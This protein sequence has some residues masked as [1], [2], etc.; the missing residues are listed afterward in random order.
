MRASNGRVRRSP[1]K[2]YRQSNKCGSQSASPKPSQVLMR[3]R[4]EEFLPGDLVFA[5]FTGYSWP[6]IVSQV[7]AKTLE[8]VTLILE[9]DEIIDKNS[10]V[11]FQGKE[12]LKQIMS[13][14]TPGEKQDFAEASKSLMELSLKSRQERLDIMKTGRSDSDEG[15]SS[16]ENDVLLGVQD[17]P[18]KEIFPTPTL[19]PPSPCPPRQ[20]P[21]LSPKKEV[22]SDSNAEI[23]KLSCDINDISLPIVGSRLDKIIDQPRPKLTLEVGGPNF[24][25][26]DCPVSSGGESE[27]EVRIPKTVDKI[28]TIENGISPSKKKKLQVKQQRDEDFIAT[29]V[30][31]TNRLLETGGK[32]VELIPG[33]HLSYDSLKIARERA[34]MIAGCASPIIGRTRRKSVSKSAEALQETPEDIAAKAHAEHL[35]A[36]RAAQ[37]KALKCIGKPLE[38]VQTT[39]KNPSKRPGRKPSL[40]HGDGMLS[41]IAA[42]IAFHDSADLLAP[43][44]EAP[45]IGSPTRTTNLQPTAAVPKAPQDMVPFHRSPHSSPIKSPPS[46]RKRR[47]SKRQSAAQKNSEIIVN[48]DSLIQLQKSIS[49]QK[50]V[51][52]VEVKLNEEQRKAKITAIRCESLKKA[53]EVKEQKRAEK[54][55]LGMTPTKACSASENPTDKASNALAKKGAKR[56]LIKSPTIEERSPGELDEIKERNRLA[57]VESMQKVREANFKNMAQKKAFLAD[58]ERYSQEHNN[59]SNK[60]TI[61]DEKASKA[62]IEKNCQQD[63]SGNNKAPIVDKKRSKTGT[64]RKSKRIEDT[65]ITSTAFVETK[66][67]ESEETPS[68]ES[69]K[70]DSTDNQDG[71]STS[72][73][74]I[75]SYLCPY[76]LNLFT[77]VIKEKIESQIKLDLEKL[78]QEERDLIEKLVKGTTA[79]TKKQA[80]AI[81]SKLVKN[82]PC[83]NLLPSSLPEVGPGTPP[84]SPKTE[85]QRV[86]NKVIPQ[87]RKRNSNSASQQDVVHNP[88]P[89]ETT[90]LDDKSRKKYLESGDISKKL[91]FMPRTW[92][93]YLKN[94]GRFATDSKS[95]GSP[96][97]KLKTPNKKISP[98][99]GKTPNKRRKV[100]SPQF[101][102]EEVAIPSEHKAKAL[103]LFVKDIQISLP[104]PFKLT[105][106]EVK[107]SDLS[108]ESQSKYI[109]LCETLHDLSPED[110]K[111]QCTALDLF[112]QSSQNISR[113]D[114]L[115]LSPSKHKK[116]LNQA[117]RVTK[118][119]AAQ[120]SET[121]E[122][123]EKLVAKLVS[124]ESRKRKRET[125]PV[126]TDSEPST[127]KE[128]VDDTLLDFFCLDCFTL[129]KYNTGEFEHMTYF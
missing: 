8:V 93:Q 116:F 72:N 73:G 6:A 37:K 118:K 86:T 57:K 58:I 88:F 50:I 25:P 30:E 67:P 99:D 32:S 20:S 7:G 40:L 82:S 51:S 49:P 108:P 56:Q 92:S 19:P 113:L 15:E 23:K 45:Q 22:I 79:N 128:K 126:D 31:K 84:A 62:D 121:D 77:N 129:G 123:S 47:Q 97:D 101:L 70:T 104:E 27:V 120:L 36:T 106:T 64:R 81:I 2:A 54:R 34:M 14:L 61:V 91:P 4:G 114:W 124:S 109:E 107:W 122:F 21:K 89:V 65:E 95:S 52:P 85:V 3:R 17:E 29:A 117:K 5:E 44:V 76:Y 98:K 74:D 41:K 59:A 96:A 11:I 60:T 71:P 26:P 43:T 127:K 105:P 10:A 110:R 53:R 103:L 83:Q 87:S 33:H 13:V 102:K 12:H 94:N 111:L 66:V 35:K 55:A 115:S 68:E 1:L 100:D 125:Q 90:E 42:E 39:V 119:M 46:T 48:S 78:P 38:I 18:T 9:Q 16:K 28:V 69:S 75:I 112:V 24:A 80:F 63:M